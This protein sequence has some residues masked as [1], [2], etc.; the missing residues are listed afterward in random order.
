MA[1]VTVEVPDQQAMRIVTAIAAERG[2]EVTSMEQGVALVQDAVFGWL[3]D[4]TLLYEA[5]QAREAVLTN[6][7]DP[8]VSAVVT[9]ESQGN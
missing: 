7:D 9:Q 4:R 1:S 6:A 5:Q 3:R 2:I 8:L